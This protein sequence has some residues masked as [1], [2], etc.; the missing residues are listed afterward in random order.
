MSANSKS[1]FRTVLLSKRRAISL[2]DRHQAAEQ[3]AKLFVA[4][5]L[6]Q[7]SQHI[8]CYYPMQDEFDCLP[9]IQ[10]IWR[11]EKK[12]YLP[13]LVADEKKLDFFSYQQNDSLQL[14]RY[15]IPEPVNKK[16]IAIEQLDIVLMPLVGFD[17]AGHRLGMGLGYY[18]K[19]FDFLRTSANKACYLFGLAFTVQCVDSLPYD[20]WDIPL[21]GVITEKNI[22]YF[23][24]S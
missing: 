6:F 9:I 5:D 16:K 15:K 21:D 2:S 12:C 11:A 17:L 18:D 22:I 24:K 7:H 19:T 13:S 23:A 1:T 20:S 10:H 8:A 3:A 4:M 14:N